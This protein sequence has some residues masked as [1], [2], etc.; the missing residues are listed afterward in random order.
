LCCEIGHVNK[1]LVAKK[2]CFIILTP[3]GDKKNNGDKRGKSFPTKY[4]TRIHFRKLSRSNNCF[5]FKKKNL[6]LA[7]I[8][9]FFN[10]ISPDV[11]TVSKPFLMN[12]F[13]ERLPHTK[14][15]PS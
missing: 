1:P 10:D 14:K 6:F 7:L 8:R 3:G 15:I 5:H 4:D 9:Q 13:V 2:K 11:I 12:G